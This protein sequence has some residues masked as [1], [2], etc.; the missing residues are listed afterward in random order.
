MSNRSNNLECVSR[1]EVNMNIELLYHHLTLY[2]AHI[3]DLTFFFY[4]YFKSIEILFIFQF[5]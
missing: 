5:T 2:G 4:Y 1:C 3:V